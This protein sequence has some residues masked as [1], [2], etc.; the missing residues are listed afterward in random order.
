MNEYVSRHLTRLNDLPLSME[1]KHLSIAGLEAVPDGMLRVRRAN[2]KQFNYTL[3]VNDVSYHQYHRNNGV[4]K[5]GLVD[6]DALFVD[7]GKTTYMIRA[8]EAAMVLS[9][10]M[11]NAYIRANFEDT[12]IVSGQQFMPFH[13]QLDKEVLKIINFIG[14]IVYP[15]CISLCMPVFLHHFVME[16]EKKLVENMKTN[17]LNMYNYWLV[18]GIYNYAS[19]TVTVFLQFAVGRWV[20]ELDFFRDTNVLIFLEVFSVWG[21]C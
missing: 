10:K 13:A 6:P 9:D 8:A 12:F 11:N 14:N 18:N 2:Q 5:L 15:V 4:S 21:L 3:Q 17:G 7:Q 19:F 20:L 16:K 1:D